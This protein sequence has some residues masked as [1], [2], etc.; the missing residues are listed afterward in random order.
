MIN[1]NSL[2]IVIQGELSRSEASTVLKVQIK[3]ETRIMKLVSQA[4]AIH[5]DTDILVP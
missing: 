4:F 5:D 3:G 2:D 1:L